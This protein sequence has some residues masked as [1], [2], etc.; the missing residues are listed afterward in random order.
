MQGRPYRS[1]LGDT[2]GTRTSYRQAVRIVEALP[3]DPAS[4]TLRADAWEALSFL[5]ANSTGER[6]EAMS[7]QRRV[8]AT[9]RQ[10]AERFP[11]PPAE[12]RARAKSD[13]FFGDLLLS[14]STAVHDRPEETR[15]AETAYL[16]ALK[17]Y[18]KLHA[19]VPGEEPDARELSSVHYRL[20]NVYHILG[21]H[22]GNDPALL[23]RGW[24]H[25]HRCVALREVTFAA[26][27]GSNQT[28]YD[29]AD[30]LSMKSGVQTL[31]GDPA[32]ALLDCRRGI[33][34]FEQMASYD[35]N[36][37]AIAFAYFCIALPE[38][39]LGDATGA[40]A[41][42]DQ[43]VAIFETLAAADPDNVSACA[44]LNSILRLRVEICQERGDQ[45]GARA[46]AQRWVQC[47]QRL[48]DATPT[49]QAM[50]AELARA[51]AAAEG[52]SELP[53]L[54]PS[55]AGASAWRCSTHA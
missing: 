30:A 36:E 50:G 31:A 15:Q 13:R 20:G 25:H 9:R 49:D 16:R 48:L 52:K 47:A 3:D 27:P 53:V 22:E 10:L 28:R 29:L 55:R 37:G 6:T 34:L 8:L 54:R 43:A 32:G 46:A 44:Q 4:S 23:A 12:Q 35:H 45:N 24:E 5:L 39:A 1:S 40:L 51:R 19:T 14:G 41:H 7:L 18:E 21:M 17:L 11:G 26:H 2:A 38:R 42:L 33:E